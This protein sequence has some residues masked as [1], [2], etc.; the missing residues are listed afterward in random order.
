MRCLQKRQS[1]LFDLVKLRSCWVL[2]ATFAVIVRVV[3]SLEVEDGFFL[4]AGGK[5]NL[6]FSS[7]S[8]TFYYNAI[9]SAKP[10]WSAVTIQ[11]FWVVPSSPNFTQFGSWDQSNWIPHIP[12]RT[13]IIHHITLP[14]LSSSFHQLFSSLLTASSHHHSTERGRNT[15]EPVPWCFSYLNILTRTGLSALI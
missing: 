6:A 12:A 7:V 1:D 8:P 9:T 5:E 2:Q 13:H 10:V 3:G 15:K 14:F 4:S 11:E